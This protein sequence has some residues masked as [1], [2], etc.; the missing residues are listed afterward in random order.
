MF[1]TW[2]SGERYI[3]FNLLVVKYKVPKNFPLGQLKTKLNIPFSRGY[4]KYK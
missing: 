2:L 4:V 1:E 3:R